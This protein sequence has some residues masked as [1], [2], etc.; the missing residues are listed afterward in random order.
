MAQR[1]GRA[2]ERR[3]RGAV[4]TAARRTGVAGHHR[5]LRQPVL[6]LLEERT[7]RG[8]FRIPQ[9]RRGVHGGDQPRARELRP[10]RVIARMGEIAPLDEHGPQEGGAKARNGPEL[11]YPSFGMGR[12]ARARYPEA[13]DVSRPSIVRETPS[14]PCSTR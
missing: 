1:G 5:R 6:D 2:E 12:A 8:P 4:A 3:P 14:T 10:Q 11:A 9:A 13:W 7:V